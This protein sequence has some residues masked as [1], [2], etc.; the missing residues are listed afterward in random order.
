MC[1]VKLWDGTEGEGWEL[2]VEAAEAL[3]GASL[4][5]SIAVNGTAIK[6]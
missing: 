4:G 2:D 1:S 5:C 3:D 6:T